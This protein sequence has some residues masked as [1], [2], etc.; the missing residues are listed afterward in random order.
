M[1]R[2][3]G[4]EIE[5]WS[6]NCPKTAKVHI[7]REERHGETSSHSSK[8]PVTFRSWSLPSA[9]ASHAIAFSASEHAA[10]HQRPRQRRGRGEPVS[11]PTTRP[12]P[13]RRK[14][15]GEGRVAVDFF[16][17]KNKRPRLGKD[18][19][20][21]RTY[22]SRS[23]RLEHAGAGRSRVA[24]DACASC[25]PTAYLDRDA[26]QDLLNVPPPSPQLVAQSSGSGLA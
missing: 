13:R 8:M 17:K 21:P 14:Y 15:A 23:R 10:Q 19:P 4:L 7:L 18:F 16:E 1:V 2:R 3:L 25:G 20:W 9:L 5:S 11:A 26:A 24:D 12:T 6:R 22:A